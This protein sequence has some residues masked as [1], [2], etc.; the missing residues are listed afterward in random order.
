MHASC[1]A[2][3]AAS[4]ISPTT[5]QS[6]Y[7]VMSVCW[8]EDPSKRPTFHQLTFLV[9]LEL[10]AVHTPKILPLVDAETH[11]LVLCFQG[12]GAL[13]WA[14]ADAPRRDHDLSCC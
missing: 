5:V 8:D 7:S 12:M 14:R 2:H 1:K 6:C 11:K 3:P 13:L 10:A 4:P 9:A